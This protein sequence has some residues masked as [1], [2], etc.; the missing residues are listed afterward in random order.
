MGR[1]CEFASVRFAATNS[2]RAM[3]GVAEQRNV[4]AH[5]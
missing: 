3:T 5:P 1:M 2:L 4:A